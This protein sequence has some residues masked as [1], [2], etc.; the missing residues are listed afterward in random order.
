MRPERK[1]LQ[2]QM[3][4]TVQEDSAEVFTNTGAARATGLLTQLRH[5]E[6][7]QPR[8]HFYFLRET[9][10]T[11]GLKMMDTMHKTNITYQ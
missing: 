10:L 8:G 2:K 7:I 11:F 3:G 5:Q 6:T 1:W 9:E 4:R